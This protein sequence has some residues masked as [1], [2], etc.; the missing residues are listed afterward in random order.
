MDTQ[1]YLHDAEILCLSV[2]L[3]QVVVWMKGQ[4]WSQSQ[5]CP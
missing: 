3:V 5:T 4:M 2:S 1:V